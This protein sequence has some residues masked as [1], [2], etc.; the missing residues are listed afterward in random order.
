MGRKILNQVSGPQL[1]TATFLNSSIIVG[2]II[3][4]LSGEPIKKAPQPIFLD[5]WEEV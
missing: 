4:W 1:G 2:G 3:K 5:L